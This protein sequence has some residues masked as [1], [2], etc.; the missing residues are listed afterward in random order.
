MQQHEQQASLDKRL[1]LLKNEEALLEDEKS[2]WKRKKDEIVAMEK[3][4]DEKF[5]EQEK[6]R[7]ALKVEKERLLKEKERNASI[8]KDLFEA[9]KKIDED[10]ELNEKNDL[11]MRRGQWNYI[12][13]N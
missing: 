11:I 7:D 4:I 13:W 12:Q 1:V 6:Q 8:E 9:R 2:S 3:K 10:R 5:H